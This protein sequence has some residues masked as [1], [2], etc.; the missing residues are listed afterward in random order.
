M[1][2]S[3]NTKR[4][5]WASI[6]SMLVCAAMLVGS[7]FAWF[8]DSVTSGKNKI[9][10]GNLDVELEYSTDGTTWN[11]VDADTNLFKSADETL[12]EPGHTEYVYLRVSNVGS[13][14][15]KYQFAVNV[16]GDEDGGEEKRIH[17][18]GRWQIQALELSGVQPDRGCRSGNQP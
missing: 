13:L 5:L 12:W 15:L 4:A 3:K 18:Q 14:A 7:T 2:K 16:Y 8:S 11:K 1:T 6:L 10:A 17:Q 9:V